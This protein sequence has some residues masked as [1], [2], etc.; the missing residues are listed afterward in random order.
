[1]GA[2]EIQRLEILFKDPV[3]TYKAGDVVSGYIQMDLA[4]ELKIK[5]KSINIYI[6]WSIP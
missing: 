6:H 5:G 4:Q 2:K 3:A 1:M